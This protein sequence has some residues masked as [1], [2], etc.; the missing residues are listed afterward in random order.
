LKNSVGGGND[1]A[2]LGF[3]RCVYVTIGWLEE[4]RRKGCAVNDRDA[5]ARLAEVWSSEGPVNHAFEGYY[6]SAAESM[7]RGMLEAISSESAQY[8]RLEWAVPVG[9]RKVLI[10]PDRVLID[11]DGTVRVQR[12][13]TGRRAKSEPEKPVYALLR[14]GAAMKYPRRRVVVETFY[15]ATRETKE[16]HH[17][18]PAAKQLKDK[19]NQDHCFSS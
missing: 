12:I 15:L 8:D 6:R 2:Y 4:E 1:S 5:L 17:P 9:R 10:T 3:H 16:K 19:E 18:P 13:R 7:V 14:R 11:A